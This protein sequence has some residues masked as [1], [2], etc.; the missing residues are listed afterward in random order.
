MAEAGGLR[1]D[2]VMG[3]FRLWWVPGGAGP[4][5]GA[6][7]R[8]P[9]EDLLDIVALESH[10]EQ[11]IVVG[12]DLGTVEDGVRESLAERQI[13]SYRLLYFEPDEPETW[14]RSAMA[15]ITTHDLPTVAGLWSGADAEEAL[16]C[17]QETPEVLAQHRAE[18]L[19]PLGATPSSTAAPE[20]RTKRSSAAHRRLA[21]APSV[22]V[23]ATLEDGVGAE[24]RPEHPG[25]A[26]SRQLVHPA[27][28]AG[29]RTCLGTGWSTGRGRI[30]RRDGGSAERLIR[31]IA[32]S[33]GQMRSVVA[34]AMAEPRRLP[35]AMRPSTPS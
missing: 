35:S 23:S 8:Y 15:A 1:I 2:H 14:P 12:E 4:A 21:E 10:R 19:A 7:V 9:S 29:S 6:Y 13:L 33:R 11:A 16:Q 28:G 18:L 30:V 27:A 32:H 20:R 34:V 5:E 22:L 25:L 31:R 24:R 17:T 26:G 3:L